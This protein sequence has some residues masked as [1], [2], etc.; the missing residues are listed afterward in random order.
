[1][2]QKGNEE[3]KTFNGT[4]QIYT[5]NSSSFRTFVGP[6][7]I[8]LGSSG[9]SPQNKLT[10]KLYVLD[11][12]G[13]V[14]TEIIPVVSDGATGEKGDANYIIDLSNEVGIIPTDEHGNNGVY[15]DNVKTTAS[16]YYGTIDDS[17]N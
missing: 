13:L 5:D 8:A 2:M 17:A 6:Q 7:T 16:V 14:D 11:G 4:L 15:G 1:M 12:T 9:F 3:P 10:I